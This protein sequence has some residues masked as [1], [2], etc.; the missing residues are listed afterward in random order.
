MKA[1][2]TSN[3][4]AVLL[5]CVAIM[6]GATASVLAQDDQK[7]DR[8]EQWKK[9]NEAVGKGLPKSGIELIGPI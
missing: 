5:V 4:P 3:R 1:N 9:V 2:T 6:A 8:E 7:V